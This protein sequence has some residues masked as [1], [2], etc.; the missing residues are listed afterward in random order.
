MEIPVNKSI[1]AANEDIA[2]ANRHFLHQRGIHAVNLIS[3]PGAGKTTLLERTV[4]TLGPEIPLAVIE[5]DIETSLDADRVR[6]HGAPAVQINT[7][8]NCHLDA[9]MVRE[10]LAQLDLDGVKLV[11]IENVGNLICPAGFD[12]GEHEKVV[13]VSVTEGEDKPP[14]YPH[15]FLE[16]AAMVINKIDLLPYCDCDLAKLKEGALRINPRLRVFE[17]SCRTGEGLEKWYAWLRQQVAQSE[18]AE[19]GG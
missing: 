18:P 7:A 12:L 16:S 4:A 8:G 3:S 13:L 5:G 19:A 11:L 1:L 14:K 9:R 10:G 15:I 17:V 6:R 2:A